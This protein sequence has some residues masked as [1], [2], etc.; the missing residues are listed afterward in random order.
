MIAIVP[1]VLNGALIALAESVTEL[2]TLSFLHWWVTVCL[3]VVRIQAATFL[4]VASCRFRAFME[5]TA[6]RIAISIRSLAPTIWVVPRLRNAA[7][8]LSCAGMCLEGPRRSHT[9]C[10]NWNRNP[11][12]LHNLNNLHSF[13]DYR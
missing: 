6:L 4:E 5:P 7:A 3:V 10:E 1:H 8:G 11:F 12:N 2:T 13:S 9:K